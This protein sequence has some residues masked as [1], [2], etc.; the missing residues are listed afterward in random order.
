[1]AGMVFRKNWRGLTPYL[2]SFLLIVFL[3]ASLV[4]YGEENLFMDFGDPARIYSDAALYLTLACYVP[5]L[6][7]VQ[8]VGSRKFGIRTSW[9][10]LSLALLFFLLSIVGIWLVPGPVKDGQAVFVPTLSGQIRYSVL[11][12]YVSLALYYLLAFVPKMARGMDFYHFACSLIF[13]FTLITVCYS[14]VVEIDCY[15]SFFDGTHATVMIP[16]AYFR[17]RNAYGFTIFIGVASMMFLESKRPRWWRWPLMLW[18]TFLQLFV[19]SKSSI[20]A[21]AIVLVGGFFWNAFRSIREHPFRNTMFLL[22]GLAIMAALILFPFLDE[23][24]LDWFRPY[25][26]IAFG[27]LKQL[28]NSI[29]GSG[30][31]RLD[32]F[33]IT[34]DALKTSPLSQWLGYGFANWK[35]EIYAFYG[36]FLP[37]DNAYVEELAKGGIVGLG[38]CI[39]MWLFFFVLIIRAMRRR[40]PYGWPLLLIY[41][42]FFSRSFIEASSFLNPN[43]TF[44]MLYVLLG[45]PLLTSEHLETEEYRKLSEEEALALPGHPWKPRGF[46]GAYAVLMPAALI[47]LY[48]LAPSYDLAG[49]FFGDIPSALAAG[50]AI[51]LAPFLLALG[52]S[53]VRQHPWKGIGLFVL[54]ALEAFLGLGLPSFLEGYAPFVLAFAPLVLGVVLAYGWSPSP[55]EVGKGLLLYFLPGILLAFLPWLYSLS[56]E[57]FGGYSLTMGIVLVLSYYFML[58]VLSGVSSPFYLLWNRLEWRLLLFLRRREAKTDRKFLRYR[59]KKGF[60]SL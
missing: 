31:A 41:L 58:D 36:G 29:D 44:A 50:M 20:M 8:W 18:L 57:G 17:N 7:A 27:R 52:C 5:V 9:R 42:G 13:V 19:M 16:S 46:L 38:L 30:N 37:I 53:L 54:G 24:G 33:Q 23:L 60:A 12:L 45:L 49:L 40:S 4:L 47:L 11:S 6:V 48:C 1:M 15:K 26:A 25:P 59:E 51:L 43:I 14:L 21:T 55:K 10:W 28:I 32:C 35:N 2:L 34:W 22:F 39:A 3:L 56:G